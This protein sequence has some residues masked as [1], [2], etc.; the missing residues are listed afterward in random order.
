MDKNLHTIMYQLARCTIQQQT[1]VA[2]PTV[3]K[4]TCPIKRRPTFYLLSKT[5]IDGIT[6]LVIK[7]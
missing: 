6:I 3:G 1:F 2:I 7:K 4:R 5:D